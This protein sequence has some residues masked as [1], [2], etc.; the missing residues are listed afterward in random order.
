MLVRHH[1]PERGRVDRAEHGVS[2]AR[3][4]VSKRL[5]WTGLPTHID[6]VEPRGIE[7]LTFRM[8]SGR[9]PS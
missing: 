7:P 1:D 2:A 8:P 9:S 3:C 5:D 4:I 6:R